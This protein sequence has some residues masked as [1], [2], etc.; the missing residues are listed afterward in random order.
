MNEVVKGERQA[1]S[2]ETMLAK[3][4]ASLF[5]NELGKA[6][7]T[8]NY[9]PYMNEVVISLNFEL[10]VMSVVHANTVADALART[11]S[12]I[13]KTGKMNPEV[14]VEGFGFA[15]QG[16][17]IGDMIDLS[18]LP[19]QSLLQVRPIIE[20]C[21]DY[22]AIHEDYKKAN[23]NIAKG[24]TA[25]NSKILMAGAMDAKKDR[26]DA[27]D[28]VKVKAKCLVAAHDIRGIYRRREDI[29][30]VGDKA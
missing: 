7:A 16:L 2:N 21:D 10:T 15:V 29:N 19:I 12:R 28:I 13:F 6:A 8:G 23:P 20:G 5:S 27:K 14:I 3:H 18:A 11:D 22:T 17:N 25:G 1:S 30:I 9:I 26:D 4:N 24:V